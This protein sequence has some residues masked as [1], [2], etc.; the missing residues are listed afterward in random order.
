MPGAQSFSIS[1]LVAR[2]ALSEYRLA[3]DSLAKNDPALRLLVSGPWA[4]Y[5]FARIADE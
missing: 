2:E 3:V 1:H 5:S 4:P